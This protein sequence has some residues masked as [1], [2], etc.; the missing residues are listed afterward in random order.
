VRPDHLG[1]GYAGI[2]GLIMSRLVGT[3]RTVQRK[4]ATRAAG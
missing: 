2:D 3:A 4:L 1:L